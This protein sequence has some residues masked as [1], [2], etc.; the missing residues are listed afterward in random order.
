MTFDFAQVTTAI[1]DTDFVA[2]FGGMPFA[3]NRGAINARLVAQMYAT[4][5]AVP[6]NLGLLVQ[7]VAHVVIRK[8]RIR[9]TR[10]K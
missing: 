5:H 1:V 7:D 4:Q 8:P 9:F 10:R 2:I 6:C 3:S